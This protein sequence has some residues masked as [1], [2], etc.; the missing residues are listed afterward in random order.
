[1]GGRILV[2]DDDPFVAR[3]LESDL[4]D[5]GYDVEVLAD[6]GL[7]LERA[8]STLPDLVLLDVGLPDLLGVEVLRAL[9]AHPPTAWLPVIL[10]TA[11]A[12]PRDTALGLAAGADDYVF[13]PFDTLELSARISGTLRRTADVRALSPLTGLPG[14]HRIDVEIATRAASGAPYAVCHVDLDE[15]KGFNDAYGFQRGDGLLL[16]LAG[17]LQRAVARAGHPAPFLGHVGGDDFVIVCTP[18]QAEPLC[19]S[20]LDEFD[21]RS[22]GYYDPADAARGHLESIDRRG[23][24]RC[25]PL[26]SVSVGVAAHHGGHQS[27]QRDFRAVVASA[28]EMKSVAKGVPGSLVAVDRRG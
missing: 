26:V 23:D 22:P 20:A 24:L 6:R 1:V 2:V 27:G 4:G 5:E 7:A 14:N 19:Q 17:C 10:L 8:T 28:N 16:L 9:R 15:F 12:D 3:F 13:K 11:R 25:Q 18:E 21:S